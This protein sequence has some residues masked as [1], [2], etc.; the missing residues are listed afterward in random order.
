ME[1]ESFTHRAPGCDIRRDQGWLR[2]RVGPGLAEEVQ[3]C[4]RAL[5]NACLRERCA[6]MLILGVS[7]FDAFDHLA[8]RDALRSLALAGVPQNFRLALVA[9]TPDLI[10]V[11]DAAVVEAER[12]DIEAR[13]FRT[14][15]EAELWLA[16]QDS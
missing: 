3:E 1:D 5:A 4:Y 9:L 2:A 13:R 10:A 6:R 12:L 8:G 11:Y 14:E 15:A 16:S 7:Q